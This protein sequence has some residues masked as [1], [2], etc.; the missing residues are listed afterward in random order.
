MEEDA[1]A[2][3]Y[4]AWARTYDSDRN[5]TRD[6]DAAVVRA[7]GLTLQGRD[8]VELGCGTGKNT[9][10]LAQHA[11]SV[12]ALDFSS[13]MLE[14]A[15]ARVTGEHVRFVQ[16]DIRA[17]WP[18]ATGAADVVVGNLVL[19][20]VEQ[21]GCVFVEAVRVLRAGGRL[22]LCELHPERQRRGGQAQFV[23]AATGATRMVP[24]HRHTTPE[25]VNAGIAAG[26]R[27]TG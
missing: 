8:V 27:N 7:A 2:R 4:D 23:D 22:H 3:A 6:L 16:H 1:V 15:R 18:L 19:E 9:T 5:A 14:H 24:A 25:Y 21:L 12:V 20:H 10:F 26:L 13:V 11:R 17:P